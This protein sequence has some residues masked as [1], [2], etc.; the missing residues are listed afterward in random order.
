MGPV[1]NKKTFHHGDLRRAAIIA[2]YDLILEHGEEALKLRAIASKCD[3]D[4]TAL[5]RHFNNKDALAYEVVVVGFQHLNDVLSKPEELS[6]GDLL[7]LYARFALERRNLY[8]AMF[9]QKTQ[10]SFDERSLAAEIDKLTHRAAAILEP[11]LEGKRKIPTDV[12]D[13]VIEGWAL[14][15]GLIDLLNR[16][17]LSFDNEDQARAFLSSRLKCAGNR[18]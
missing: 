8:E 15:H 14:A 1:R 13:R 16:G 2:A 5:Y 7:V 17:M 6:F 12:R 4:H 10:T 11:R 3:V 9:S 18:I